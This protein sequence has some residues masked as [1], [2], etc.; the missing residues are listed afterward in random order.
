MVRPYIPEEGL[1]DPDMR[2]TEV[3]D[4]ERQLLSKVVGQDRA[5]RDLSIRPYADRAR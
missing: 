2:S 1:L 4:F 5:V 3:Q